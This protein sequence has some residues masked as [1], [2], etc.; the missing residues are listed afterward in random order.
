MTALRGFWDRARKSS[1]VTNY[2]CYYNTTLTDKLRIIYNNSSRRYCAKNT[3]ACTGLFL[4]QVFSLLHD[5]KVLE[6]MK[7]QFRGSS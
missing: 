6:N 5:N 3:K 4:I 1:I 2:N 7:A